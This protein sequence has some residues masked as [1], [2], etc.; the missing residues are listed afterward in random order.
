LKD[1]QESRRLVTGVLM[2][3]VAMFA[4]A[5]GREFSSMAYA[6][7]REVL[8]GHHITPHLSWQMAEALRD[9]GL[10]PG[11]Q[12]ASIGHANDPPAGWARL[13]KVK[14][15]AEIYSTAVSRAD[16]RAG[17]EK[18][19]WAADDASRQRAM[20][21]FAKAGAQAVVVWEPP[22]WAPKDGWQ[23]VGDTGYYVHFFPR[24][25]NRLLP[26][27]RASTSGDPQQ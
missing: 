9:T 23:P 12:V 26:E 24:P 5:N 22:S 1:T 7:A 18:D 6:T 11:D 13:A 4:I 20:A 8:S 2:V 3:I 21:T 25:V 17:V 10:E 16:I 19:F 27:R 15:I 14:I